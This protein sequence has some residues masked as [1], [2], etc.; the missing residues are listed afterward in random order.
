MK[1]PKVLRIFNRYRQLGGEERVLRQIEEA[2]HDS[3]EATAFEYGTDELL[4]VTLKKKILAPWNAIHN[5]AVE[6][7]L[8]ALQQKDNFAAWEIH[9]VFPAFS[10]SVYAAAFRVGVPVIQYLHNYRLSCVNGMFLNH[11]SPCQR[12]IGGNFWPAFQTACWHDNHLAGGILGLALSRLRR[13]R[14]FERIPVWVAISNAQKQLHIRMGIPPDR[15]HVVPH[16]LDAPL[17]IPTDV[18]SLGY[19]LFLGR[20]SAEKGV[21]QLLEGWRQLRN[22]EAT[23]VI[24]GDGP[25]RQLLENFCRIHSLKNVVFRGFVE[26]RGKAELW[27][28]ARALIV[29]SV[30]EEPFGLV[31]L[32]AWAHGRAALVSNRGAL[33]E[34]VGDPSAQFS[35]DKPEQIAAIVDHHQGES[36]DLERIASDGVNRLRRTYN[37]AVW[38]GRIGAVYRSIGLQLACR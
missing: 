20:L 21:L 25:E 12:C 28:G 7:E 19:F 8:R 2:L 26:P 13:L 34:I 32:E 29:P 24:A 31:V 30:W 6:Q 5:R 38:L 23:L 4:G 27:H 17:E 18:P 1:R 11:G 37:R 14:T 15:I 10:P 16:F 35:P 3:V 33:A 36:S 9:N 22:H